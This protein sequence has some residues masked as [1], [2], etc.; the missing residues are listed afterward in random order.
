MNG[1]DRSVRGLAGLGLVV[2]SPVGFNLM[3]GT[4]MGWF[5]L[6]FGAANIFATLSGVCFMYSIV[7]ISSAADTG[8]VDSRLIKSTAVRI[9]YKALRRR[10]VLGFGGVAL[11]VSA[12]YAF[13]SLEAARE[14]ARLFEARE[15]HNAA[16][17]SMGSISEQLET[18]RG[19]D[20]L[21][22]LS[23]R[24][25]EL[26]LVH[27]GESSL[28]GLTDGDK[29][30]QAS[31]KMDAATAAML[32]DAAKYQLV[33]SEQELNLNHRVHSEVL[34]MGE[35]PPMLTYETDHENY[36]LMVHALGGEAGPPLYLV[37]A[38]KSTS[39]EEAIAAVIDNLWL[40][41]FIVFWLSI[42]G[43]VGVSYFISRHV[44]RANRE[45]YRIATSD[46]FTGLANEVGLRDAMKTGELF[47][48]EN[49]LRIVGM[50]L[51]DLSTI[52]SNTSFEVLT[53]MLGILGRKLQVLSCST[54]QLAR[55]SDGTIILI[56]PESDED[57]FDTF[58][59][60]L[61]QNQKVEN[62][63]FSL[64]P[65]EVELHY[66]SDVDDFESL[67]TT[68][69]KLV[70]VANRLRLPILRF[71]HLQAADSRSK[72]A[73]EIRRALEKREFELYL[74][75]KVCV[76]TLKVCGAEALV[77]WNHP[78][79]GLL[80][81]GQFID[82]IA[83]SNVRS[84][85]ACYVVDEA[86]ALSRK[87]RRAGRD[88][89]ISFNLGAED[90]LDTEVQV[91]LSEASKSLDLQSN[92]VLE[93]ELT[94]GE[95]GID[96]ARIKEA[97]RILRWL[98]YRI[99]LDDFGTGMSS[100]S[101]THEL[102]ISTVKID[103]S[104][105]DNIDREETAVVP[106]QAIYLLAQGY[107]YSVVAEGVERQSQLDVLAPLGCEVVQ[108]YLF[109]KPLS[110]DDFLQFKPAP[111]KAHSPNVLPLRDSQDSV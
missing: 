52:A 19:D 51:R 36:N 22:R 5:C 111:G 54:R 76:S 59:E 71:E 96:P 81:P 48:S 34:R 98:G 16:L 84:Q 87:L 95:T 41:S 78:Q 74:Q 90:V 15:L 62:F 35:L 17:V 99:A 73:P 60:L 86:V 12:L 26:A 28:V 107:G 20:P 3:P 53:E 104:F 109:S 29:W 101:Y 13:Q 63:R 30:L 89:D 69:A 82:V 108:G 72:Y 47:K 105:I 57:V 100:L 4:V 46:S 83:N 23:N 55:L 85:F 93:I 8:A 31:V 80:L 77:R 44:E 91:K 66:P 67:R 79:D 110:F 45:T 68:V 40:S 61:N 18:E 27:F 14:T 92:S 9:D 1:I 65:T 33:I 11:I 24:D 64:E 32:I 102:P 49:D 10:A 88:L 25:I 106:I 58:R 97:L 70:T 38:R 21:K 6:F 50:H 2:I 56:A 7:G 94:E 37:L 43:A 103:K 39:S 42:W 75:P